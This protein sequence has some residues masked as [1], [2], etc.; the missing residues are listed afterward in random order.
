MPTQLLYS[1][2]VVL[3]QYEEQQEA[4]PTTAT[5]SA[6]TQVVIHIRERT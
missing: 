5:V 6:A 3:R 4:I 2:I 1:E